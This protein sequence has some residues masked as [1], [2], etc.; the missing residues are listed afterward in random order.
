MKLLSQQLKEETV[1]TH[2]QLEGMMIPAIKNIQTREDYI[3]LLLLFYTFFGGLELLIANTINV[4][5]LTDYAERRKIALIQADLHQLSVERLPAF[6]GDSILP[7]VTDSNAA[8]GA[9][10][11]MEGS[12]LGGGVISKMIMERLPPEFKGA[13]SFFTSYGADTMRMWN[14]FKHSLDSA[15]LDGAA[16]VKVIAAANQTFACF[17]K[18]I[19]QQQMQ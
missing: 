13:V 12:T 7:T 5:A 10:Y 14:A 19:R 2:R 16:Q 9:L 11:V 15:E 17:A 3:Q 4:A 8:W 18:W 1:T 6:C